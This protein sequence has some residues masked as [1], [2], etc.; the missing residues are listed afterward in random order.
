MDYTPKQGFPYYYEL[1][2]EDD[3]QSMFSSTPTLTLLKTINEENANYRYASDKWS[4]K[5]IIGHITDH[6]RIK[7]FRAFQLS[8]KEKVQL[9][10][11]DQDF[12]VMNS[13][14]DELSK[15][16]LLTD[17]I[18]IRK[19][20]LSFIETLSPEQ[21]KIKGIATERE[22]SLEEFLKTI[23]GHERHHLNIVKEKYLNKK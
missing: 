16:I 19:A 1:A 22:I 11:Y 14:F 6:E 21:L 8:R 3:V 18:N 23:I 20:S 7:M 10:G 2:K 4:I 9:W 17:Y 13:R 12:L 15:Q 5:Q